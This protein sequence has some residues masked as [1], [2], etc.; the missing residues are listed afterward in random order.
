[1]ANS[2]FIFYICQLKINLLHQPRYDLRIP[3]WKTGVLP[4]YTT[5]AYKGR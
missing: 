4:T 1:M 2:F 3:V 5:G